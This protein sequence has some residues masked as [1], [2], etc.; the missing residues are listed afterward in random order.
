MEYTD[1]LEQSTETSFRSDF[2]KIWGRYIEKK[3]RIM[4]FGQGQLMP[5][6]KTLKNTLSLPWATW[7]P[8]NKSLL[9]FLLS[10]I[11]KNLF[12]LWLCQKGI[13][14]LI[15]QRA[16]PKTY[17]FF[18]TALKISLVIQKFH[19]SVTDFS[20]VNLSSKSSKKMTKIALWESVNP[21]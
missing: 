8:W 7:P 16:I 14:F 9:L 5:N 11:E 17:K 2:D 21:F 15:F 4:T 1:C 10:K 20:G 6:S 12:G 19:P 13:C 18:E 3:L